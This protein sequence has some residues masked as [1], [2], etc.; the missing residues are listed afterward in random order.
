MLRSYTYIFVLWKFLW[1]IT[2][3][4]WIINGKTF[5]IE[6]IWRNIPLNIRSAA[7]IVQKFLGEV[8]SQGN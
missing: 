3:C 4:H 2:D 7:E 5:L 8:K 6:G 1:E